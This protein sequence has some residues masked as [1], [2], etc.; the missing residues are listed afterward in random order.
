V[1]SVQQQKIVDDVLIHD[2][3]GNIINLGHNGIYV[4]LNWRSDG[5]PFSLNGS[6]TDN[7]LNASD[8]FVSMYPFSLNCL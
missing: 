4:H 1:K 2:Y 3:N 8:L 7:R 5:S 6:L